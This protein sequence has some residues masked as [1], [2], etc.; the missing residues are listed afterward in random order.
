MAPLQT[1]LPP[2]GAAASSFSA[3]SSSF[4]PGSDDFIPKNKKT[5]ADYP[6]LGQTPENAKAQTKKPEDEDPCKGKPKEFFIYEHDPENNVCF[7]S[8]EQMTFVSIHYPDHYS[9]PIDILMWLYD[10]AE[11][12]DDLKEAARRKQRKG[13]AG[14][15]KGKQNQREESDDEID[16][17]DS[18]FGI[19][20]HK[21]M[22]K[23]AKKPAEKPS[24]PPVF[25][26]SKQLTPAQ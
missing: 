5:P 13:A 6:A 2:G 7:C 15:G 23:V 22:K 4:K 8:F 17:E 21:D 11:Y 14:K 25:G 9:A 20:S 24:K 10:M 3:G 18:T 12:R 26:A 1:A 16:M 19:K